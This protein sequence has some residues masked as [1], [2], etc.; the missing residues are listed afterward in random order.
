MGVG[1]KQQQIFESLVTEIPS[2]S[3]KDRTND[4]KMPAIKAEFSG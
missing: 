2:S 1:E 3:S 4:Q